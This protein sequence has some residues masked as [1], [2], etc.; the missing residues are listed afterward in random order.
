VQQPKRSRAPLVLGALLLIG[1][2][3]AGGFMLTRSARSVGA[4]SGA[5]SEAVAP[6]APVT[7]ASSTPLTGEPA[8]ASPSAAA[9]PPPTP[10]RALGIAPPGPGVVGRGTAPPVQQQRPRK[11]KASDDVDLRN[12]YR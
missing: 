11:K 7:T 8:A 2:L 12:P 3:G 6:P 9:L 5:P 10:A 4:V 1:L